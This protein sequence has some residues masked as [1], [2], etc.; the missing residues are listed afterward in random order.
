M[1]KRVLG[2]LSIFFVLWYIKKGMKRSRAEL[3]KQRY[4]PNARITADGYICVRD[5]LSAAK[6]VK[7]TYQAQDRVLAI[8]NPKFTLVKR[9][10]NSHKPIYAADPE[11][12]IL[13]LEA[14]KE[15]DIFCERFLDAYYADQKEQKPL[16]Q[17]KRME[18]WDEVAKVIN[19]KVSQIDMDIEEVKKVSLDYS[20]MNISAINFQG[21]KIQGEWIGVVSAI[22]KFRNCSNST[23][24]ESWK[25]VRKDKT[26]NL[27]YETDG[28]TKSSDIYVQKIQFVNKNDRLSQAIP[29]VRF[30]DLI[31]ILSKVPGTEA[32][33]LRREQAEITAR[34]AAG[35][36]DLEIGIHDRREDLKEDEKTHIFLRS[37]LKSTADN[38]SPP[39]PKPTKVTVSI[40]TPCDSI[41][42]RIDPNTVDINILRSLLDYKKEE[43]KVQLKRDEWKHEEARWSFELKISGDDGEIPKRSGRNVK[44]TA[45]MLYRLWL[46]TFGPDAKFFEACPFC[47]TKIM[48]I[49]GAK[50]HAKA[51]KMTNR[52][53]FDLDN[54]DTMCDDCADKKDTSYPITHKWS[55]DR[56]DLWLAYNKCKLKAPCHVCQIEIALPSADWHRGHIIPACDDGNTLWINLRPICVACNASCGDQHLAAYAKL[57]GFELQNAAPL[58]KAVITTVKKSLRELKSPPELLKI[59]T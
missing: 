54:L 6:G 12:I 28:E 3:F 25:K 22:M 47:S 56:L 2:G 39:P 49:V 8:Q 21:C 58:S 17:P 43:L 18:V 46:K 29:C 36:V 13:M 44:F 9:K 45:P 16:K 19:A 42:Q 52:E 50:I 27:V 34:A 37:G 38:V 33:E 1:L 20:I 10:F 30:I 41:L 23:A 26:I 15:H 4:M 57:Q 32:A 31:K 7:V 35:D 24:K 55:T 48:N 59:T 40:L 51:P 14:Y 11:N 53:Y 5:A